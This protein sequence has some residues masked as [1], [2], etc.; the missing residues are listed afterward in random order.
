MKFDY[1]YLA[2]SVLPRDFDWYGLS[3]LPLI[4]S[5][6]RKIRN[7]LATNDWPVGFLCAGLQGLGAKDLGTAGY[8]GF[9]YSQNDTLIEANSFPGGH[10]M[11]VSK[12]ENLKSIAK[13][14]LTGDV[15][16]STPAPISIYLLP[17]V[18]LIGKPFNWVM[19]LILGIL[20]K[21]AS[22][23]IPIIVF[24]YITLLACL[25]YTLWDWEWYEMLIKIVLLGVL[26]PLVF[27]SRW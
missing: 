1:A 25:L 17:F 21:V 27:L 12:P 11:A 20:S 5:Q 24:S 23:L 4:P 8:L 3:S 2:G 22:L 7:D 15:E 10:S 18:Y 26:A 19:S 9:Q 13:F 6:V 14:L 16:G